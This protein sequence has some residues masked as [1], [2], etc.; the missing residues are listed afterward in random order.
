MHSL[1]TKRIARARDT[2]PC[3]QHTQNKFL[4]MCT[5]HLITIKATN[6]VIYLA[7]NAMQVQ[8]RVSTINAAIVTPAHIVRRSILN[9]FPSTLFSIQARFSF[10]F[11][12]L[13]TAV[14]SVSLSLYT[15]PFPISFPTSLSLLQF[16]FPLYYYY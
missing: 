7:Y 1:K 11:Q 10:F 14:S 6:N 2:S 12:L 8:R 13:R 3:V 5:S 15:P 16:S 4:Q 9:I